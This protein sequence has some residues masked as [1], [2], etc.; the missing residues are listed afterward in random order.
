MLLLVSAAVTFWSVTHIAGDIIDHEVFWISAIGALGAAVGI[1]AV[2][3]AF[4]RGQEVPPWLGAAVCAVCL[5]LIAYVGVSRL[6]FL[7]DRE[8]RPELDDRAASTLSELTVLYARDRHLP[9]LR[10]EID[11]NAWAVAAG[12]VVGLQRAEIP[13]AV[14]KNAV[15]MFG[16]ALAPT[17]D[18]GATILIAK[19]GRHTQAMEDPATDPITSRLGYFAD[20]IR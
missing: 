12:V 7:I 1:E 9:K 11:G 16:D 15:W 18:E 2:V 13:F 17:G 6:Q 14:D 10:L 8:S 5:V 3:A 20:R 19:G 4:R